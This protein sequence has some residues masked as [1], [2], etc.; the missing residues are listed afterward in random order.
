MGGAI[1]IDLLNDLDNGTPLY[2][3]LIQ[4]VGEQRKVAVDSVINTKQY[5]D[6][7]KERMI[8]PSSVAAMAL[9]KALSAADIRQ[10]F[11]HVLSVDAVRRFKP[12][13][14]AYRVAEDQLGAARG[15]I[16]FVSSNAWDAAGAAAFGLHSHWLNRG[17]RPP[18][19]P[20]FGGVTTIASLQ[21]L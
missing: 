3:R 20:Q 9:E 10:H 16:V 5:K 12:D 6:W 18:E 19:Y 4:L 15:E 14:L 7:V 1:A 17:G 11:E 8:G 21:D 13:P 2:D